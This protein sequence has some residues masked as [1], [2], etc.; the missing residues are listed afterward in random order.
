M[1]NALRLYF[2]LEDARPLP[3]ADKGSN[4]LSEITSKRK[5]IYVQRIAIIFQTGVHWAPTL[6]IEFV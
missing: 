3:V 4:A 2:R 5:H 1:Y 6:M